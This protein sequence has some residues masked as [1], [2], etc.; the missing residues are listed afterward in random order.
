M[1]FNY[2]VKIWFSQSDD[3]GILKINNNILFLLYDFYPLEKKTFRLYYTYAS[4][5]Q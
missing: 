2:F 3:K 4:T 1:L 5:D